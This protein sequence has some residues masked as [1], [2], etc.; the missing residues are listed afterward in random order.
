MI[1]VNSMI[2]LFHRDVPKSFILK[3]FSIMRLAPWH[4][5]QIL[6]KRSERLLELS[7]ALPWTENTWM[8][9]S[10]ESP[11]YASRIDDMRRTGASF[12]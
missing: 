8:G 6:T 7:S 4:L 9:V 2:D 1:F 5:L 12:T 11:E 3:V 10:V